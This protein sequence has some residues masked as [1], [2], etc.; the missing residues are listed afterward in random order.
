MLSRPSQTAQSEQIWQES[1]TGRTLDRAAEGEGGGFLGT[2]RTGI[3]LRRARGRLGVQHGEGL[4]MTHDGTDAARRERRCCSVRPGER[5][6]KACGKRVRGRRLGVR[7]RQGGLRDPVT[8]VLAERA[9]GV[10]EG[11]TRDGG[12]VCCVS[13]GAGRSLCWT[14]AGTTSSRVVAAAAGRVCASSV[15]DGRCG[16]GCAGRAT[17][18]RREAQEGEGTCLFFLRN[19]MMR[20]TLKQQTRRHPHP[21]KSRAAAAA[22]DQPIASARHSGLG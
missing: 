2:A 21:A 16:G 5:K 15:G 6:H 14:T 17:C 12:G 3:V 1:E 7:T 11:K 9:S 19:G 10:A 22:A 4:D 18:R 13:W 20:T 8:R